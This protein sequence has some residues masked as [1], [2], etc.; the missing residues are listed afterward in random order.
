VRTKLVANEHN[1]DVYEAAQS[2]LPSFMSKVKPGKLA[3]EYITREEFNTFRESLKEHLRALFGD[4]T[5]GI[6]PPGE[7]R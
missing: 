7:A 3:P 6:H 5:S 4:L 1:R 2:Y